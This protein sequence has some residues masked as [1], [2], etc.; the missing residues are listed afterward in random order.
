MVNY[1]PAQDQANI[2]GLSL[3]Q[4]A[5]NEERAEVV[6]QNEL[7]AQAN[8][9]RVRDEQSQLN[10]KLIQAGLSPITVDGLRGRLTIQAEEDV[11]RFEQENTGGPE[12][13]YVL[14]TVPADKD[15]VDINGNFKYTVTLDDRGNP[16]YGLSSAYAP[17]PDN[18]RG[19]NSKSVV[20]PVDINPEALKQAMIGMF[21]WATQWFDDILGWVTEGLEGDGILAS[22]RSDP[23]WKTMFPGMNRSDGTMRFA[24]EAMYLTTVDNYRQTLN[25]FG[26][27]DASTESPQD[28]AALMETGVDVNEL[29]DRLAT[30]REL[31]TGSD[32]LR[33]AFYVHAGITV[34]VDDL[35]NAV[36]DPA[37][38]N[39][40][41]NA[42]NAATTAGTT[43]YATFIERATTV[44]VE[45]LTTKLGGLQSSGQMSQAQVSKV[46][47][48]DPMFAQN[49]MG[50]IF[51][52][53][54]GANFLGL[55]EMESAF[56]YAVLGSAATEAGFSMP[57]V[58]TLEKFIAQ[59]IDGAKLRSAYNSLGQKQSALQGMMSRATGTPNVSVQAV[60]EAFQGSMLGDSSELRN[61]QA[62][63]NALGKAGGGFSAQ[64]MGN[65][66][67]QPGRSTY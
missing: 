55:E 64:Q 63:E 66:I 30:Y 11:A 27:Y 35:F 17:G 51:Q 18:A 65:R 50:A 13:E 2:A 24:N 28:Y 42:Y 53:P 48:M 44:G 5:A 6:R 45:R 1:N 52:N 39:E 4:I 57:D 15:E 49:L 34:T 25:D 47:R 41:E 62:A 67:A 3:S 38:K 23:K 9:D 19:P 21:P 31:E 26:F 12:G 7:T 61:A 40:L 60:Q 37:K 22:I 56:E 14:P 29:G 8:R 54:N 32:E 43:D 58:E 20:K 33:D 59:G 36:V 16:V 10:V 46:L